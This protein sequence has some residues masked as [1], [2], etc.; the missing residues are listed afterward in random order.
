MSERTWS[1]IPYCR[2]NSA[3]WDALVYNSVNGTLMHSRR[4]LGYH[5]D[6]FTDR[7]LEIRDQKGKLAGVI[8]AA[9]DPGNERVVIAHPG[10]TYGGLVHLGLTGAD[11][12]AVLTQALSAW[13][14]WGAQSLQYKAI[15]RFYHRSPADQDIYAL[16]RLGAATYR[17]DLSTTVDLAVPC[18]LSVNRRRSI[19][20]AELADL[21]VRRGHDLVGD[22]VAIIGDTLRRRHGTTPTHSSEELADLARRFPDEIVIDVAFEGEAAAATVVSFL[23]PTCW[24]TQYLAASA[25]GFEISALDLILVTLLTQ[26]R[27]SGRRWFDFGIS[28]EAAGQVLN[29]GLERYKSGFG[30]GTTVHEFLH[31]AL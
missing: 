9:L 29:E 15:P 10:L 7:S 8:P 13:R 2:T 31:V 3:E 19:R 27:E 5:G 12:L 26:A 16:R 11:V 24:H 21:K 22:A 25:R 18:V 1:A 6:R 17:T 4:Y 23:T 30:A 14:S 20:K 28:T